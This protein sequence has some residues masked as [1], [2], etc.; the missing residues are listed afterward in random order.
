MS[1]LVHPLFVAPVTDGFLL[2]IIH[3]AVR[4]LDSRF[5]IIGF[6]DLGASQRLIAVKGIGDICQN[7]FRTIVVFELIKQDRIAVLIFDSRV[8]KQFP[9]IIFKIPLIGVD[10]VEQLMLD[11]CII[12]DRL[13]YS[14]G[15]R[16]IYNLFLEPCC[17]DDRDF[18]VT[19]IDATW[20][21][22]RYRSARS[23]Q[24]HNAEPM[25]RR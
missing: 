13:A 6:F 23:F 12:F 21:S 24:R 1:V 17:V 9:I 11:L 16:E 19:V 3:S 2:E 5:R 18:T 10:A 22:M 7:V 20:L 25:L 14:I 8:L 15:R 4:I